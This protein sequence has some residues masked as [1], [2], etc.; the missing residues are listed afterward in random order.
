M[1]QSPL[2]IRRVEIPNLPKQ[3]SQGAEV[4]TRRYKD[5][6]RKGLRKSAIRLYYNKEQRG[7]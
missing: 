6:K 3:K 1:T 2:E 4:K 7:F 5:G